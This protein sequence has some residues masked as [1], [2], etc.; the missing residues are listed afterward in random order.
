[1]SYLWQKDGA[2]ITFPSAHGMTTATLTVSNVTTDMQGNYTCTVTDQ[3]GPLVSSPSQLTVNDPGVI[4]LTPPLGQTVTN[5]ATAKFIVSAAGSSPLNYAW[6][7]NNLPLQENSHYVGTTTSNLTVVGVTTN[8]VGSY[9]V[10]IDYGSYETNVSLKVVSPAQLATNLL[11]N[12]GFEDGVWSEPWENAWTFFNGGVLQNATDYYDQADTMPVSVW[13]GIW[14]AE[15]YGGI[16]DSDGFYQTVPVT[17]GTT[18]H[19]G[20]MAYVPALTPLTNNTFIVFQFSFK[21]VNGNTLAAYS[22]TELG[23]N[24]ITTNAAWLA[25]Q[26]TNGI[27][28]NLVA[29]A[30]A[31]SATFQVFEY[32]PAY[33]AGNGYY[34]DLYITQAAAPAPAAVKL[35]AAILSGSMQIS[36]TAASGVTYDV[37]Y[38]SSPTAAL[39]TWKTNTTVIGTG[40]VK[41]VTDT[42]GSTERFYRVRAHN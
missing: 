1:L 31:V 2:N 18:Y 5:G 12:P 10:S 23:T 36:F 11:I 38:S 35:S 37:L 15:T 33:T 27:D 14:V 19:A 34:D 7:L 39:S 9:M 3:G 13:D 40:S 32:D 22:S 20:G 24:G 8:D 17:A 29:P 30:G 25:L 16:D 26:V 6:F 42:L 28:N 4:S 21:D 41:S